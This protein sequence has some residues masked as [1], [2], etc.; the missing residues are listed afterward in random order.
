MFQMSDI[1]AVNP[2][3]GFE[4]DPKAVDGQGWCAD[5]PIFG[6]VIAD[7]E[8]QLIVEVGTWKGASA[9][10]MAKAAREINPDAKVVCVDTWL[11]SPDFWDN[12]SDPR[13]YGSFK[14]RNGYPQVYYTFLNNI[15]CAGLQD[16]V[17]PFPSTSYV[18]SEWFRKRNIQ[19]DLVYIDAT[20]EYDEVSRDIR[21][22]FAVLREGG[23]MIGDD[24]NAR[25]WPGVIRAVEEAALWLPGFRLLSK[26]ENKWMAEKTASVSS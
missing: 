9:M 19:P 13:T 16:V 26:G 4:A 6:N 10:V 22:W 15:V 5:H 7:K 1:H 14:M 12:F 20:H 25:W 17:I 8:P 2:Y 3:D 11:G 21:Q 18:A 23:V 24:Y